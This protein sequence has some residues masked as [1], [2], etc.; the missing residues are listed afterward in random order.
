MSLQVGMAF[1]LSLFK[2]PAKGNS[3]LPSGERYYAIGDIH[4][5]LDLLNELLARIE[6][7]DR[8]R[9]PAT[10]TL[11]FIG[12]LIDRGPD[13]AGVIDALMALRERLPNSRFLLGNHEELFLGAL[14]GSIEILKFHLRVGGKATVLSYGISEEEYAPASH[15]EL[16]EILKARVPEAH[17]RFLES[18]EDMIIAGDYVF[19]HAGVNPNL[20]L[21]KQRVKDL[22][23][24][25]DSFLDHK[26]ALEKTVVHGHTIVPEA[27]FRSNR[28]A[29]DTGAYDSG[30]LTALG[31]EGEERWLLQT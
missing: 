7:D 27:Q 19:V 10:T 3:A 23:W 21:E 5:R 26:G 20:P 13:S 17:V 9:A 6:E 8:Q 15:V 25:R 24:I 1:G 30:H 16:L 29:I 11:V 18:F 22:R 28:I 4:G 31:L 14:E 2:R 12:D